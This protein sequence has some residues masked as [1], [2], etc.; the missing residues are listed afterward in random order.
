M[1]TGIPGWDNHI[2]SHTVA[3]KHWPVA[4]RAQSTLEN[5]G[6]ESHQRPLWGPNPNVDSEF[7]GSGQWRRNAKSNNPGYAVPRPSPALLIKTRS[8]P[9]CLGETLNGNQVRCV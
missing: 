3:A 9:I 7:N 4:R 1:K 6:F 8:M 5:S 2:E